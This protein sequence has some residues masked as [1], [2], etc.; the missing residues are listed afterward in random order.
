MALGGAAGAVLVS[1]VGTAQAAARPAAARTGPI[2]VHLTTAW[3]PPPPAQSSP[4]AKSSARRSDPLPQ[5]VLPDLFAVAGSGVTAAQFSK[6]S[7]LR[8]VR[9]L[10]AVDGGGVEI[11][12]HIVSTIGVDTGVFRSWTPPQT[13][14]SQR[15]W[16]ALARD[17]LMTTAQEA[18]KLGLRSGK[19]YRVSGATQA[20][21]TSGGTADF[22]IPR[23][24]AVVNS[25]IS[26]NLGLVPRIGVLL[27]APGANL[28]TLETRVRSVLGHGVKF[29]NLR[30]PKVN[31]HPS[32]VDLR[33]P[34]T[35]LQQQ[36]QQ[37]PVDTQQMTTSR[38]SNYLELFQESARLYCPGLSWTVLAAIGQIE[39]GDR[40]NPGVSSAGALGP[41]QFLS[42]TWARW[43]ITAFG[44]TGP[45]NIMD[46]YDAVPSAARY[47]C[48]YGAAQGGAA[49]SRAIFGYNHAAWY[50]A[51]VLALAHEYAQEYGA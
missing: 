39:S 42:S 35:A 31:L 27:S 1:A 12:G 24:E 5:V 37:W 18:K 29:V 3:L 25:R 7:K 23:V 43:G 47:L 26:R 36:Q 16:T 21:I 51:E 32:G 6:L 15:V 2:A 8:Y 44:E 49:L 40:A 17:E 14:G 20:D 48:S 28:V 34:K 38:P 19:S 33:P 22:G 4:A 11:Q 30:S 46:P 50:V 13:A 41:M 10:T 9:D 45:P